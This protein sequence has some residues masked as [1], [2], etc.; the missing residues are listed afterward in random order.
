MSSDAEL[1][2]P[3]VTYGYELK[4]LLSK[5]FGNQIAYYKKRV[6]SNVIVHSVNVNPCQCAVATTKGAGLRDDDLT[7]AFARLVRR[8]LK[9]SELRSWPISPE[10]LL[11]RLDD[12]EPLTFIFNAIAWTVNPAFAKNHFGY[13]TTYSVSLSEKI[14]AM[15]SDWQSLVTRERSSKSTAL[16]LIVHGP[17]LQF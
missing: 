17:R 3:F 5:S 16:S 12:A 9:A 8:K 6:T 13:A 14:W 1:D 15:A 4:D 10:E 7:N 11:H 2:E